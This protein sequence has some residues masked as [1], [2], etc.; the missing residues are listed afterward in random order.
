[1]SPKELATVLET[2][3]TL[4]TMEK[5]IRSN[6]NWRMSIM[7]KPDT[8]ICDDGREFEMDYELSYKV[9]ETIDKERAALAATLT[10]IG[11]T[12]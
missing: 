1:M 6:R 8:C 2:Y 3:E 11:V 10:K 4:C 9:M 7:L 5:F 12:L